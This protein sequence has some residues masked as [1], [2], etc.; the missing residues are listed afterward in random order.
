VA[1]TRR[2]ALSGMSVRLDQALSRYSP[3][4]EAVKRFSMLHVHCVVHCLIDQ[5]LGVV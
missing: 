4:A 3:D 2:Y 1:L 5:L